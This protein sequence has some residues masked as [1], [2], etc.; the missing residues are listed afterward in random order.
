MTCWDWIGLDSP[1]FVESRAGPQHLLNHIR[2]H[3]IVQYTDA[4]LSG[5]QPRPVAAIFRLFHESLD[6]GRLHLEVF[7]VFTRLPW[8]WGR[9]SMIRR[10]SFDLDGLRPT[11]RLIDV[12]FWGFHHPPKMDVLNS[13]IRVKVVLNRGFWAQSRASLGVLPALARPVTSVS[14]PQLQRDF[15]LLVAVSVGVSPQV[16]LDINSRTEPAVL[17]IVFLDASIPRFTRLRPTQP[18][19]LSAHGT[20]GPPPNVLFMLKVFQRFVFAGLRLVLHCQSL[21]LAV[22]NLEPQLNNFILELFGFLVQLIGSNPRDILSTPDLNTNAAL[23]HNLQ[24]FWPDLSSSSD[25]QHSL[26]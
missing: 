10:W 16:S 25:Y 21:G 18:S 11:L 15:L 2:G 8:A 23:C 5:W 26:R 22:S 24:V 13:V 1:Q 17:F 4:A 6:L 20:N 14:E 19:G 12:D 3:I 9:T 7:G